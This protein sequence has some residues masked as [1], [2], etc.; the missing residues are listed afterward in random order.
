MPLSFNI[1]DDLPSFSKISNE[2][3]DLL[4][5]SE[6][7]NCV[8]MRAE[9]IISTLEAYLPST[10]LFILT[11]WRDEKLVGG[12]PLFIK[13]ERI[14]RIFPVKILQFID[15]DLNPRKHI[16]Y[17]RDDSSVLYKLLDY[18]IR[19]SK[20]W[21]LLYLRGIK[22][23]SDLSIQL[24]EITQ[25]KG[26][27]LA[28]DS[29]HE[30]VYIDL[31]TNWSKYF[32]GLSKNKRK[33]LKRAINRLES[34]GNWKVKTLTTKE[35]FIEFFPIMQEISKKSWKGKNSSDISAISGDNHFFYNFSLKAAEQGWLLVWVL[36]IEENDI[37]FQWQIKYEDSTTSFRTDF[38]LAFDNLAPGSCLRVEVL[39]SLFE[40][41]LHTYDLGGADYGDKKTWGTK[42][43]VYD[44]I[45]IA[46]KRFLS[47]ILLSTKYGKL[48]RFRR[49]VLAVFSKKSHQKKSFCK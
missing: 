11:A 12:V 37:V 17:H 31:Q 5:K 36:E 45:F 34:L 1:I 46:N 28:T 16:L 26:L 25:S 47:K 27:A 24:Q 20:L 8:T 23:D 3:N 4:A 38:D 21:D 7:R 19:Q 10:P 29:K 9:W 32:K 42:S 14:I 40:S 2:W 15:S 6:A 41:N 18:L 49:N 33:N 22:R 30:S 35:Q 48:S 43:I 39:K 13:D 44:N